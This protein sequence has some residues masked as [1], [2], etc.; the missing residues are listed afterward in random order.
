MDDLLSTEEDLSSFFLGKKDAVKKV[1]KVQFSPLQKVAVA[2]KSSS[3]SK[4]RD[5]KLTI[6]AEMGRTTITIRDLLALKEGAVLELDKLAGEM[7]DIY[8]NEH[9]IAQ[10]EVLVINDV[11][12]VRLNFINC[13]KKANLREEG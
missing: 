3:L 12:G 11:F 5:L 6:S 8:V 13:I 4:L 2:E 1:K 9:K 7:T 10:G